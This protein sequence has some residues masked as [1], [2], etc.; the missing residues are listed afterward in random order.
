LIASHH[1]RILTPSFFIRLGP[2]TEMLVEIL[3][4][5]G[6]RHAAFG[7]KAQYYPHMGRAIVL[8]LSETMGTKWSS[9]VSNAW[10]DVYDELAGEMMRSTLALRKN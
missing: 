9:K 10:Q 7:V 5:L 4:E 2:D 6:K 3:K 8:V 1:G